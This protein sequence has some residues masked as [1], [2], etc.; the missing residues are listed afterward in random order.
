MFVWTVLCTESVHVVAM[1]TPDTPTSL[2]C[3]GE[4]LGVYAALGLC[5]A[6]MVLVGAFCLA[7]GAYKASQTLHE[8]LL[9]SIL[10]SPMSFFDTTPLGRILN[11]FSKD[12]YIID[13]TLPWTVR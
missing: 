4:F 12:V 6:L 2:S 3:R 1:V 13:Q 10:R 8:K 5:Q 9:Y 11:R 7:L